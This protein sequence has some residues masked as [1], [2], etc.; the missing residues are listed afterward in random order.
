MI[1]GL[2]IRMP[3]EEL[4]TRLDERIRWHRQCVGHYAAQLRRADSRLQDPVMPD[5]VL[6]HEMREHRQQAAMLTLIREHLIPGEIYCL[7]EA[8][9]QF[10]DLVPDVLLDAEQDDEG[11]DALST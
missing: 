4:A 9:L 5:Q 2:R 8:D 6:E 10:A 11:P 1:D 7:D 3:S